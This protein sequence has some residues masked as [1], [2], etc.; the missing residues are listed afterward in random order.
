MNPGRP[1][2]AGLPPR[3]AGNWGLEPAPLDLA[4]APPRAL[5]TRAGPKLGRRR[6]A[7]INANAS[8]LLEPEAE[9]AVGTCFYA[10]AAVEAA[11]VPH[12]F[13]AFNVL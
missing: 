2:P 12:V 9:H 10:A 11:V 3:L 1:T 8:T 13:A 7:G 5:T 4:R 6:G